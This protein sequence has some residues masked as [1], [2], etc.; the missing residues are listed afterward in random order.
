VHLVRDILN[1]EYEPLNQVLKVESLRPD[2]S[3]NKSGKR[4]DDNN[5]IVINKNI[6]PMGR[7]VNVNRLV[8]WKPPEARLYKN[9]NQDI[10]EVEE[11]GKKS[12]NG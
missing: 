1:L 12:E 2:F 7:P 9:L 5:Q 11:Y 3:E 6:T 10:P 4:Y 8:R